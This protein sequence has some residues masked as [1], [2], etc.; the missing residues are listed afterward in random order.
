MSTT[1]DVE[2]DGERARP[3][4]R[5]RGRR[6]RPGPP[7]GFYLLPHLITTANLSFGFY[8]IVQAFAGRH[9]L[10]ALGIVLAGICDALDG[11]VARFVHVSSRFGVEY[12]SIADTVS[13]GVAPA[14]LAFSAGNLEV[15]G[16]PGWVM[17]FLFT[18]CAALRLARFNVSPG[19]YRG[20]FEGMPSPAAAGMV[21]STQWFVSFLR[22][23][24]V[25]VSAPEI[26]VALGVVLLGLLMVSPIP[27]RSFK[28]LDLRHSYGTLVL[29]V[30]ALLFVIQV[31]SVTLFTIGLAYVVSGPID[32][33]WRRHT[34]EALEE[35]SQTQAVSEQDS[36]R[37]TL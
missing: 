17:A 32:W 15:L 6:K 11:R 19:R 28:E 1:D 29:V 12:D 35:L 27:Y 9:D 21:A 34:G 18:V 5:G 16:R 13:F 7:R 25:Q 22:E 33:L 3:K 20:R 26:A 8:A 14:M 2:Y 4:R 36:S 31:P 24:G 30:I 10:S 37:I 23:N